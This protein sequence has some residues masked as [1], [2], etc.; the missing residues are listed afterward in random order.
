VEE[1]IF[2]HSPQTRSTGVLTLLE[3]L[4][5][6]YTLKV[7]NSRKG[8][9]DTA[10]FKAINPMRKVPAV[11]HRGSVITEQ[12][13]V[14]TYLADLFPNSRMAPG[15]NDP[16]RGEYLRWMSFYGSSFEPAIL[17]K[18]MKKSESPFNST[19][20]GDYETTVDVVLGH[21]DR[22]SQKGPFWLGETF[23]AVDVLWGSALGWI[24]GFGAVP[25]HPQFEKYLSVISKRP[26]FTWATQK[27]LEF[28]KGFEA[29]A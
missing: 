5:A 25:N 3:E 8:A 15:V 6:K 14:Y 29:E 11:Q 12:P 4:K 16:M 2:H 18:V 23:T 22:F 26:A 13:A 24:I 9:L 21:L 28:M 17:D 7:L 27:D 10:E 1:I 19:P 20:Y